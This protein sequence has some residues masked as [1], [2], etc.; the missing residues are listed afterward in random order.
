MTNPVRMLEISRRK[1]VGSQPLKVLGRSTLRNAIAKSRWVICCGFLGLTAMSI[2]CSRRQLEPP[3]FYRFDDNLDNVVAVN[4]LPPPEVQDVLG[5]EFDGADPSGWRVSRNSSCEVRDGALVVTA[6]DVSLIASPD[7]LEIDASDAQSIS[8]RMKVDGAD[9]VVLDWRWRG[10][11]T[12][13]D[14]NRFRIYAPRPGQWFSYNIK[15]AGLRGWNEPDQVASQLR[16][17][18]PSE[19]RV[20]LDYVRLLSSKAHF[21]Q[22]AL[23]VT[24][25]A[26]SNQTRTCLYTHC[27]GEIEYKVAIPEEAYISVGLGIVEPD[28]PVEF[29]VAVKQGGSAEDLFKRQVSADQKWSDVK[30]DMTTYANEEVDI[31]FRAD[32]QDGRNVALWSNPI[33]YRAETGGEGSSKAPY[34]DRDLNVIL[35]LIDAL[36]A[37]HLD[38]YGYS[39]KTAPTI[40]QLANEGVK[41]AR[42]FSQETWTKPSISSLFTGTPS[43]VHGVRGHADAV[44]NYMV[45]LPE[46]LRSYG[47]ATA[48][49]STN[50]HMGPITNLTRGSS[51]FEKA[52]LLEREHCS[53][54]AAAFLEKHADRKVFL[55]VHTVEPHWQYKPPEEFVRRFVP[56]GQDPEDLDLYDGEIVRADSNLELLISNLKKLGICENT[57]LIVTADHGEA[58]GEH[59]GMLK[60][61]EKPYNELI[62]IPL[63]MHLPGSLPAGEVVENNVQL[64][65]IAPTILDILNIQGNEQFQGMS[66]LPLVTGGPPDAGVNRT[67]YATGKGVTAAI[68]DDWKLMH[69]Q[70]RVSLYDLSTDPGETQNVASENPSIVKSLEEELSSHKAL[71]EKLA[72]QM[73]GARTEEDV[74]VEVDPRAIERLK[75]LGYLQ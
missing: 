36:R 12:V 30:I 55:Y 64:I 46:I 39:R 23:G 60:H 62:H 14:R 48:S 6:R 65:D 10:A 49:F 38:A 52:Y 33:L 28:P 19:A 2:G 16:F 41:F 31:V 51:Y 69:S 37:D 74:S 70:N 47:Y 1:P 3:D 26:L 27:P 17:M 18:V 57:L 32:C 20:E 5:F 53:P 24:Q 68:R 43:L 25:Y 7:N 71:Q 22:K 35:Y 34:R 42:C 63:I 50:S 44:P 8:I 75:A 73:R 9:W 66:L 4:I 67:V 40:T 21:A 13:S 56:A 15:T 59:E 72:Q 61:G 11:E 58:F 45:L 29:S 54:E